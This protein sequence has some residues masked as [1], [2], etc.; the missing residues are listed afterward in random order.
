[1]RDE[2]A[3]GR[4]KRPLPEGALTAMEDLE[5]ALDDSTDSGDIEVLAVPM[6]L[7]AEVHKAAHMGLSQPV[8]EFLLARGDVDAKDEQ[9]KGTM[10]MAAAACQLLLRGASSAAPRRLIS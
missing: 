7:P 10:L 4:N 1:M 2:D 5:M 8:C 3:D 9:M 6:L